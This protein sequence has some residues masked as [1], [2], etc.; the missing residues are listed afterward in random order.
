LPATGVNSPS[1]LGRWLRGDAG[2]SNDTGGADPLSRPGLLPPLRQP[3]EVALTDGNSRPA[4]PVSLSPGQAFAHYRI[5]RELGRGAM[6]TVY[7]ARDERNDRLLALKLLTIGDDWPEERLAEARL[8]LLREAEA[9]ARIQ[10]PDIVDIYEAGEHEG[11]VFLAMEF[12]EGVSLGTHT[13]QGRLLPPRMVTEMCARVADALQFAH[14]QGIVHRDIKPANIIFDQ[15][16]RRIRVMDFGV[17]RLVD[18]HAT[19]TGVVLGSPSYMAPEQLDGGQISGQADLF[20]LGVSL[21]Q[22][23]TGQLP[24]RSDSIPGLMHAIATQPHAP[25][26]TIR[27]DLPTALGGALDRALRKVPAE[28]FE[29]AA[30]MARALHDCARSIDPGLR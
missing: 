15:H 10:H 18:S 22:L 11:I 4:H 13:Y 26:R 23:L 5:E 3:L 8:R 9:A 19:R 17:A 29:S 28:R 12:I 27:P 25:L 30:Q 16:S 6:A 1:H 24:F 21:F 14:Q 7:R 2:I 20:S